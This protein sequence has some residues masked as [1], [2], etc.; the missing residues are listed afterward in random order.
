M[1]FTS[2]RFSDLYRYH[3]KKIL[4][5]GVTLAS[6]SSLHSQSAAQQSN[7]ANEDRQFWIV[8]CASRNKQA[9]LVCQLTQT[10]RVSETG[11]R[12]LTVNI[13]KGSADDSSPNMQLALP[14]GLYL[15]SGVTL[16]VDDNEQKVVVIETSDQHGSYANVELKSRL[17]EEFR[18]G[19]VLHVTLQTAQKQNLELQLSLDGF[20]AAY[21]KFISVN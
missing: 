19:A 12:V 15:P 9:D 5:C 1:L 17:L 3:L 4:V 2:I 20:S 13:V 18:R 11:Q 10:L 14:H 16:K 6:L 8:N 21:N 7:S